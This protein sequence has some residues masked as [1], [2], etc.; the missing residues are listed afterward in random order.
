MQQCWEYEPEKRPTFTEL[1]STMVSYIEKIA[2]YLEMNFNTANPLLPTADTSAT[3]T[4]AT[5]VTTT[6]SD[7]GNSAA[8]TIISNMHALLSAADP[9]SGDEQLSEDSDEESNF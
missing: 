6:A 3:N 9:H 7:T 4:N 8:T 1:Y 5:A 2:G